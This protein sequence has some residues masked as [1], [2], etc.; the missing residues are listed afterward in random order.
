M[1]FSRIKG[2]DR[3]I[4]KLADMCVDDS[5]SGP[6]LFKGPESVGKFTIAKILSKYITCLSSDL[7][8]SCRCGNCRIFPK[9]PDYLE[10]NLGRDIIKVDDVAPI[11]EYVSL[12]PFKSKKKV[13]LI[14]NAEN[15]NSSASNRLL[16]LLETSRSKVVYFFITSNVDRMMPTVVSRC[17]PI[18]FGGLDPEHIS[19]ILEK[20]H[21][22]EQDIKFLRKIHNYVHGGIL[23]DYYKYLAVAKDIPSFINSLSGNDEAN[24][25][26]KID[27]IDEKG[28][29]IYFIELLIV[30]INDILK[31]HYDSVNQVSFYKD[32][33]GLDNKTESW[34]IE[35]C[36]TMISRLR[37]CLD[38]DKKGLNLKIRGNVKSTMSWIFMLLN[39]TKN[40]GK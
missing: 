22:S 27:E 33:E 8:P 15:L 30:Y 21:I 38:V 4:S 7:D 31:M 35:V 36:L 3:T 28:N 29:L 12:S 32:I 40:N 34:G 1:L 23:S 20:A 2:H 14:N 26:I 5:F 25:L 18:S 9:S 37:K 16:K 10:I 17:R 24:I 11:E 13:V 6:Y 19:S 39:R